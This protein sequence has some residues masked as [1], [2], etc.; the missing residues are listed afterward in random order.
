[1]GLRKFSTK[2]TV[3]A[4]KDL[5]LKVLSYLGNANQNNSEVPFYTHQN[6]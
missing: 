4:E 3:M 2:E 1:M 5:K 6:G